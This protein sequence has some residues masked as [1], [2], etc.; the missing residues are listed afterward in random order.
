MQP[1][2]IR[3]YAEMPRNPNGKLDRNALAAEMAA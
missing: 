1:R 3:P 2:T